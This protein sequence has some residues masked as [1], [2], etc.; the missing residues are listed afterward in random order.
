[1]LRWHYA[2]RDTDRRRTDAPGGL[3]NTRSL[4]AVEQSPDAWLR[5]AKAKSV[6]LLYLQSGPPTQD[7]F[8]LKPEAPSDV[9]GEFKSIA[10]SAPGVEVGELLPLT[11]RWMLKAAIVRSVYH[12]A[13]CHLNIP[14]YTGYDVILK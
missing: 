13:A 3:C 10:T 1:M 5:P 11:A 6:V 9:A 7:M 8:D 2:P 14:M 4:L 12:Q